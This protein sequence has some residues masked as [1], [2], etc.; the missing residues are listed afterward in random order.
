M[1][2]GRQGTVVD[3]RAAPREQARAR[4]AKVTL[5]A[6]SSAV[7]SPED[8]RGETS[9]GQF[10]TDRPD[11]LNTLVECAALLRIAERLY[12]E[13]T[14]FNCDSLAGQVT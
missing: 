3:T 5:P 1:V 4:K 12:S 9:V 13:Q 7:T 2:L 6:E 8:T 11:A 10:W 14:M